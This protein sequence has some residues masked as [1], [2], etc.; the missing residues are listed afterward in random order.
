[1]KKTI[2][3]ITTEEAIFCDICKENKVRIEFNK[4]D[5]CKKDIC[6]SCREIVDVST[7]Y[8]CCLCSDCYNKHQKKFDKIGENMN[9]IENL[10]REI[11]DLKDSIF[12]EDE[13]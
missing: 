12:L 10:R 4:C 1:M 5:L 11:F 8:T 7:A 2:E 9:E 3:R 13:K 6:S